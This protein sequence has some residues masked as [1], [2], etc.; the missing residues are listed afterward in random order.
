MTPGVPAKPARS[1]A[2]KL[3]ESSEESL[4]ESLAGKLW[5]SSEQ[6]SE[7]SFAEK[8]TENSLERSAAVGAWP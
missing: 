6:S 7:E 4:E 1:S 3:E 2:G 8:L 5:E